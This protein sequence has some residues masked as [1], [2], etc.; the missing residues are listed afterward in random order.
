[1]V[2]VKTLPGDTRVAI[3]PKAVIKDQVGVTKAVA[4]GIQDRVKAVVVV[5]KAVPAAVRIAVKA[6]LEVAAAIRVVAKVPAVVTR[7]LAAVTKGPVAVTKAA[8]KAVKMLGHY[9]LIQANREEVHS[10]QRP[11][12]E[13]EGVPHEVELE[14]A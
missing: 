2:A 11:A 13:L 3:V 8:I 4:A 7:A 12:A 6:A 14:V 10:A 9:Y 5:I 1:M